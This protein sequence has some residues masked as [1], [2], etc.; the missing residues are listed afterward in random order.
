MRLKR[1]A[2]PKALAASLASFFKVLGTVEESSVAYARE[3]CLLVRM[4][5]LRCRPLRASMLL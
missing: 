3:K 1:I 4:P 2:A 5:L